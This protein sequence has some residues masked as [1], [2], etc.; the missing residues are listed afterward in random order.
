MAGKNQTQEIDYLNMSDEELLNAAPPATPVA[1]EEPE[2][3]IKDPDYQPEQNDPADDAD[4][5]ASNTEEDEDKEDQ[6]QQAEDAADEA[7]D[8]QTEE[9][10]DEGEAKDNKEEAGDKPADSAN[11]Q[12]ADDKPASE[13][14]TIDFKSEYERLLAPFKAN[15][16]DIKVNNVDEAITLMQMGANY[17]KK[18]A[19]LK[20]N[21][22]LMK[23]LENNGLL[24]EEKIGFLIDLEKKNPAA[25]NKLVK[26][27]GIDPMDLDAEK[28]SAYKQTAYTVDDREI[29]LD[30]VLDELQGSPA[31]NRT[32]EIVSTKWDAASKQVIAGTPQLLKVINDHVSS[33][34]YDMISKEVEN[35]RMFGRLNGLSDIEAYR[36]IGDTL[37]AKGAFNSLLQGSSQN[38]QQQQSQQVVVPPKPK[39]DD[40]KLKEKRRAA[41]STKPAAPT[42]TP[43]DFDPLAL[44][45]EEFSKLVNKQFL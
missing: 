25:I 19:A 27:S 12:K 42:T 23:L 18:M 4:P 20:P 21:L 24:S 39:A 35:E 2:E 3:E 8:S 16:R 30:T 38:Q 43:K 45:D 31:Y 37:H 11:S 32:L 44:S 1:A 28:A 14:T 22:K 36:K 10:A 7:G 6:D 17:N 5:N 33:G 34:I 41:S 13:E 15:G 29:E 9:K 26:D 40:D